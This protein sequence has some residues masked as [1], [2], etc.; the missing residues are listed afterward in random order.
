M[1]YL[2]KFNGVFQTLGLEWFISPE[3]LLFQGVPAGLPA[4]KLT[5]ATS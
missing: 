2:G 4:T 5:L 3:S 1:F